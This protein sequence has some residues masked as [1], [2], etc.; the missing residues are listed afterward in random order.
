MVMVVVGGDGGG[1]GGAEPGDGGIAAVS[2]SD[3]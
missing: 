2:K 1:S 3:I